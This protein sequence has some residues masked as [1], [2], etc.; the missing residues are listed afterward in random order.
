MTDKVYSESA[1]MTALCLM[2]AL[3]DFEHTA[4]Y[5]RGLREG[6]GDNA[7]PTDVVTLDAPLGDR[8]GE[9]R[10]NRGSF[11]LRQQIITLTPLVDEAWEFIS[12][13]ADEVGL[14]FDFEFCPV[15]IRIWFGTDEDE[16]VIW[17]RDY[18]KSRLIDEARQD[19]ARQK[20]TLAAQRARDAHNRTLAPVEA[21]VAEA[22]AALE[23]AE[24]A[25]AA[26]KGA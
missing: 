5:L 24:A 22:R 19:I 23:N 2:D 18:F 10:S 12:D 20:V 26:A 1:M 25:L 15:A 13:E 6:Q 11:E 9:Y 8:L 17:N 16:D 14:S 7:T 3:C 4:G 21:A